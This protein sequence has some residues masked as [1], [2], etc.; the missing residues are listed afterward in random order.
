MQEGR[1]YMNVLMASDMCL[2]FSIQEEDII[3]H[4]NAKCHVFTFMTNL[5]TICVLHAEASEYQ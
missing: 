5:L 3:D 4:I 1:Y 2:C